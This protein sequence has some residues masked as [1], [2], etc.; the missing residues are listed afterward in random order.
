MFRGLEI[1]RD[2]RREIP[3]AR[4]EPPPPVEP[5]LRD[6]RERSTTLPSRDFCLPRG[7]ERETVWTRQRPYEIRSSESDVLVAA[8]TF[9]VVFERDLADRDSRDSARLSEDLRHLERHGLVMRRDVPSDDAGHRERVVCLTKEGRALLDAHRGDEPGDR[10]QAVHAGWQKPREVVHDASLYRMYQVEAA[11]IERDG[12]HI[13]R[14][15]LGEDLKR[16]YLHIVNDD[17]ARTGHIDNDR[18]RA[19]TACQLPIVNGHVEIPDVRVEYTTAAGTKGRVDL[20]LVTDAYH[21]GQ[22]AAK[23]AAGFT[24]YSAG[25]GNGMHA[26]GEPGPR[27]GASSPDFI[28]SLLTI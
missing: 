9:R 14:V 5:D 20:E 28:S 7:P 18:E 6:A 2:D 3:E 13:E 4:E 27:A 25:G 8:G 22:I 11:R 26:L 24:L 1:E 10:R 16:E 15:I 12:G 23:R 19:A 21:A 17:V